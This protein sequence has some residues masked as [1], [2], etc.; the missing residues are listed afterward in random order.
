MCQLWMD[1]IAVFL[2]LLL[3]LCS[4]VVDRLPMIE[5][6][7]NYLDYISSPMS[8]LSQLYVISLVLHVHFFCT[9]YIYKTLMH[10]VFSRLQ[11]TLAVLTTSVSLSLTSSL[12][13]TPATHA[14][15]CGSTSQWRTSVKHRS[16]HRG[17]LLF[18][19]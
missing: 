8:Y 10:H 9:L 14:S 2:G 19:H 7:G 3:F 12:D 13:P 6:I 1:R 5:K 4:L 15:E 17:F 18:L 16:A 11:G